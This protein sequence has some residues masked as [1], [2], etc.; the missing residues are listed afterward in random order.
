MTSKNLIG[1]IGLIANNMSKK[2]FINQSYVRTGSQAK[3]YKQIEEE[4][5]CPFCLE[6]FERY[7][8]GPSIKDNTNWTLVKAKWPYE[9]S[10]VHLIFILKKHIEG[11]ENLDSSMWSDLL[12]L[13]KWTLEKY[14]ISGGA[15]AIRFGDSNLT[16]AT[17]HHLHAHLIEPIRKGGKENAETVTFSIG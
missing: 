5:L 15:F 2:K 14:E 9:N 12:Q 4:G 1:I 6:N 3:I 16:G 11:I 8:V 10:K 13:V 7:K 17:V